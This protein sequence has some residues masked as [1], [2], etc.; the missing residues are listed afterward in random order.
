MIR[1]FFEYAC[2]AWYPNIN[3]KLKIRLQA[4]QNKCIKF[5]LKLN[6]RSSIKSKDF[7]K[8]NWLPIHERLSQRFLCNIYEFFYQELSY[9]DEIQVL[10]KINGVHTRSSYQKLNFPHQKTNVKQK[11]LSYVGSSL[12]NIKITDQYL[13]C[14]CYLKC[15][16][17]LFLIKLKNS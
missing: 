4:A 9:F 5:C 2:N 1:L 3:K 8:I 13:Y 17:E 14:L 12:W 16:K 6:D 10:L 11:V 7:A 15:L